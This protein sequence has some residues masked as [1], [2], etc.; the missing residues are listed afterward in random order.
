MTSNETEERSVHDTPHPALDPAILSYYERRA[1][2]GVGSDPDAAC[3]PAERA[4]NDDEA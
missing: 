3:L 4:G 2:A 1:E